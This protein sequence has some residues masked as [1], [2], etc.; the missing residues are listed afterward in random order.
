MPSFN[1]L[2]PME[3]AHPLA[4][5]KINPFLVGG[6]DGVLFYFILKTKIKTIL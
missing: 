6:Y 4:L 5:V 2:L 3:L 1:K